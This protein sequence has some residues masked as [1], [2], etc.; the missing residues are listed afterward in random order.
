MDGCESPKELMLSNCSA[1]DL[2]SKKIKP[3]NLKG[4]QPYIFTG[5]NDAEAEALILWPSE[6][7]SW[8]IGKDPDAG[9][10]WRQKE[11][12]VVEDEMVRWHH[13]LNRHEFEP[14][15]GD[16]ERQ[17]SLVCC[18]PWDCKELNKTK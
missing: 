2:N 1:E 15:L 18:S 12:G 17:K 7:K 10:D 3:V 13:H 9:E 11:M 6:A 14:I 8:L 4:N 16:S 5:K